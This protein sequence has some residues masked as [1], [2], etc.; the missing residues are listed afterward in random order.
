MKKHLFQK[1]MCLLLSVT[2]LMGALGISV[3]AGQYKGDSTS[4]SLE[5]MKALVAADSYAA[6]YADYKDLAVPGLPTISVDITN[7]VGNGTVVSD[8]AE[9][10]TSYQED[11]DAWKNFGDNWDS[12]VYLSASG[13]ASWTFHVPDGSASLYYIRFEYYTCDTAESS[14]ST[15]ER[16]F[17]LDGVLP[18]S[19][20][21]N[22]SLT[23][24]WTYD[25]IT[26][27]TTDA[28]ATDEEGT[29]VTYPTPMTGADA[30]YKVVTTVKDG[31]K[32]VT[33]YK[34]S[35][36]IN[37]NSMAPNSAQVATW[38][39]Y[40]CQDSTGYHDGYFAFYIL[41]GDH[42]LTL[43]AIRE[44]V[45]I[46]SIELV[47]VDASGMEIPKYADVLKGYEDAG[48]QPAGGSIEKMPVIQAE[49][50]DFV[51]DSSVSSTNDNTSAITYPTRSGAQLYNVI[52]ENG[53]STVGQWAAYTFTVNESGLYK[54]GMR[55]KQNALQGMY[56]CRTIKLAG[57]EYG[58]PDGTPTVPFKEAYNTKF[59]YSKD[60]QSTYLGDGENE[61]WFHFEEGVEYTLYLECSL[62]SLRSLIQRVE[63]SLTK[64]NSAYLRILQLTGSDPDDTRDYSFDVVMPDVLISLAL[65]AIELS[66]VKKGFE[67]LCGTNGSH[68]AT[69]DTIAI[70]LDTMSADYGR[71]V[72]ANMSN[73]KSYLGTLGTWINDSKRSSMMVDS[74]HILS[75][76]A[77]AS[78]LPRANA[79]FFESVGFEIS[80]FF[81]SFFTD[82]DAMGLTTIPTEDTVTVDVWLASGRD[83]SQIWR[84]MIDA[85]DGFTDS[86]GTAVT[87]KLVTGGTLL[88]SILSGKGPDVYIGL[89]A[90]DVINYAIREAVVGV[91]GN[92]PVLDRKG[93]EDGVGSAYNDVFNVRYYTYRNSDGT[94]TRSTEYDPT[95]EL[96]FV[97]Q[98]YDEYA[99][100]NF[101]EAAL[102]TLELCDVF[103][104]VPAT[105]SF[106][107]MFYRMDIL[108]DLGEEVPETW[109]ELLALLPALQANNMN[110][111]VSYTNALENMLY[112][113]GGS[114]WRFEDDAEYQGAAIGLDTDVALECFEFV[115]RLYSDYS[116]PVSFDASNRFRTGEM[117]LVI[118]SYAGTY[119]TLVV[120]ATEI[121][122]LWEFCSLPGSVRDDGTFNYNSTAAISATVL[123]A[124]CED[125]ILDAWQFTQWESSADVQ[126][127]YGNKMVALIGPS[128]KY[129]TANVKAIKNL[130]WTAKE[131]AAIEDQIK[132]LSSIVNYPGSYIYGR[133][134]KFAFL[135][136]Q[137]EGA[138]PVDAL[139]TYIDTINVE[140]SRK[141]SEFKL[142]TYED[143]IKEHGLDE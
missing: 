45:I 138:N 112:Q 26:T 111:G 95:K 106:E 137:N 119:N 84:T 102:D 43:E 113:E 99:E 79:G 122:G 134:V 15:I 46:K 54:F 117:P 33:T 50:P 68:I 74:I 5:E 29:F 9:C 98:T 10:T 49:F 115:C 16:K 97:S 100:E 90:A 107:M 53:Y 72:A 83:Q 125:N 91:S 126:A 94:Y 67:E 135:D 88:P 121:A 133:Y 20:A 22:I 38:N 143:Y 73:L 85:K 69:L 81:S 12:T 71:N 80:S 109:G 48:Y 34:L 76:S 11:R 132:N 24:Q 92:D 13:S 8:S 62:G 87:L 51:S 28:L 116:F 139:T 21:S 55:Y 23:K 39:T 30:Y 89:G 58:L 86:T 18:F 120:Y 141:R 110:I 1:V 19:E 61:F 65:E 136:V 4:S 27:E 103:Y 6:Y 70:L 7:V 2:T 82:Y 14:I 142:K 101:V 140:I 37:G 17:Y 3:S 52:G 75:S 64:I 108:A 129:E 25:N 35:Q 60:W 130:S 56:I 114:I 47:P 128:A 131:Y 96:T 93:E 41:S 127:T 32:T 123:L 66:E 40:Y 31:K 57:G 105:M 118:G 44:P 63:N 36:D 78:A 124:G 42:T 104:G 77:D 59:D